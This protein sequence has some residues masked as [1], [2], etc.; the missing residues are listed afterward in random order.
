MERMGKADACA[1]QEEVSH[2]FDDHLA[3]ES[4]VNDR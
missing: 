2:T 4:L 3:A 1:S